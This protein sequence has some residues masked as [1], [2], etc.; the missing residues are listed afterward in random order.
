MLCGSKALRAETLCVPPVY[1]QDTIAPQILEPTMKG[2]SMNFPYRRRLSSCGE[3]V[4]N[5]IRCNLHTGPD[6]LTFSQCCLTEKQFT[7]KWWANMQNEPFTA[8]WATMCGGL[9]LTH[10]ANKDIM[11]CEK[12]GQILLKESQSFTFSS[13]Q[14]CLVQVSP[15][16]D[17]NNR[18]HTCQ[19][20][21]HYIALVPKSLLS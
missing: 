6:S 17:G 2:E 11:E 5:R 18:W 21:R 16:E 3:T 8:S 10:N 1:L 12:G 15:I 14:K 7:K 13:R 20:T 19:V 4:H 9:R